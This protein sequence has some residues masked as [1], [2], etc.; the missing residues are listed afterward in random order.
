MDVNEYADFESQPSATLP[1]PTRHH[2][3]LKLELDMDPRVFRTVCVPSNYHF[4]HIHSLLQY[5]MGWGGGHLHGFDVHGPFETYKTNTKWHFRLGTVKKR[6]EHLVAMRATGSKPVPYRDF[7]NSQVYTEDQITVG[8]VWTRNND[9]E[10]FAAEIPKQY[11]Y[12]CDDV[13]MPMFQDMLRNLESLSN[14][15]IYVRYIYD[16]GGTM[17][18]LGQVTN[19][20]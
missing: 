7:D 18:C 11:R 3:I 15:N 5:S 14:E 6:G 20:R 8:E 16:F 12:E 19:G 4:G 17:S 2:I 1:A 13:H 10:R 9:H